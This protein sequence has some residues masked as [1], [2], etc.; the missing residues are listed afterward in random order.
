MKKFL[1]KIDHIEDAEIV[2]DEEVVELVQELPDYNNL[3]P[4]NDQDQKLRADS[5]NKQIKKSVKEAIKRQEYNATQKEWY[6]W[7]KRAKDV[8]I[9]PLKSKR[10]TAGQRKA[11]K[12]SFI[13][14]EKG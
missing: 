9:E 11:W 7:R 10:P 4:R 6:N 12:D 1:K 14:A 8:G 13:E 5:E 3:P 2:E